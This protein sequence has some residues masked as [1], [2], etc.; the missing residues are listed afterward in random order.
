MPNMDV[1]PQDKGGALIID[2]LLAIYR[3]FGVP[4]YIHKPIFPN[5]MAD[6][7]D[8]ACRAPFWQIPHPVAWARRPLD[9]ARKGDHIYQL[10]GRIDR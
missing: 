5:Q 9:F 8:T 10:I 7:K 4:V 1:S 2:T 3:C 6:P